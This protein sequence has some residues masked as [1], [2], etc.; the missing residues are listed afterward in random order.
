MN[1]H[2]YMPEA[3]AFDFFQLIKNQ[4]N[5]KCHKGKLTVCF[6]KLAMQACFSIGQVYLSMSF[7]KEKE[8]VD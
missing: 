5:V 1:V 3:Q 7:Y 4:C 2:L 8:H 6:E